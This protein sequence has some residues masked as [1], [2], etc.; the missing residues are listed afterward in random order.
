[1]FAAI[2][3]GL[4]EGAVL[5]LLAIGVVLV[6]KGS[7]VLN[8]AQGE[9]GALA[10]LIAMRALGHRTTLAAGIAI[11]LLTVFLG[12]IIGIV[13]E[14][15]VM[16][17]LVDRPPVQGTMATLG[18]AIIL[19]QF[20]FLMGGVLFLP[21]GQI[22][23][24]IATDQIQTAGSFV[25]RFG[26]ASL[27]AGRVIAMIATAAIAVG[28]YAF[29]TRTKFGLGVVAATSDGTVARILGIPVKKVYRFT[30][31]VGGAL[32][33]LAAALVAPALISFV[34]ST[35]TFLVIAALAA[36]VVGGLD[37]VWG[38]VV[39]GLLVGVVGALARTYIAVG[40]ID[41]VAVLV[42]VVVT[43]MLRPR[44]ILG[45]AGAEI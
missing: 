1:M 2:I 40:S 45:G 32:S 37:S 33:G 25:L 31:G 26:G 21:E 30:W 12:A 41:T 5:A 11:L 38:A 6:Y 43:L 36:A 13:M 20:E 14:R 23:Y 7:K 17:P 39:G 34:P 15:L 10:F 35:M 19:I 22:D 8:L 42:L 9:M 16:R 29:F 24:P 4:G 44:G 27:V 18:V 3:S 28:L